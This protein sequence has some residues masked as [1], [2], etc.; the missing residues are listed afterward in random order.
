M[1]IS[2]YVGECEEKQSEM[3]RGGRVLWNLCLEPDS[4]RFQWLRSHVLNRALSLLLP[5]DELHR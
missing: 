1:A 4:K 3:L 2:G 5:S